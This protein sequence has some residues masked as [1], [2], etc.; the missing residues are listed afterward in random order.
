MKS[1]PWMAR[2]VRYPVLAVSIAFILATTVY[3]L[4]IASDLYVSEA[5]VI[6]ERTDLSSGQVTDI[7][8]L[9]TGASAQ[10][11][12]QLLLREYLL[13]TDVLRK[14]EDSLK[15]REHFATNGDWLSRLWNRQAPLELL[16][17]Y[18]ES[19]I[20]IELDDFSDVLVINVQAYTPQMSQ[21]IAAALL[22]EGE[23]YMNALGHQLA[24]EQVR[25]LE[26][27]VDELGRRTRAARS[28]LLAYQ[29]RSGMPSPQATADN[30]AGIVARLESQLTDLQTRRT[31]LLAFLQP[32]AP[33]VAEVNAQ[34]RAVESQLRQERAR[35]AAPQGGTL[36][37]AVEEYQRLQMEADFTQQVF[38]SA[39]ASLE[40]GRVDA[41]RTLKQVQVLQGA[42]K[43]EYP[44]RPRRI[45]NAVVYA[46]A[47][48]CL[49]G[50]LQL[51]VA[52]VRDHK[53]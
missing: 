13:S 22:G 9:L 25:F 3:W 44:L 39:L 42:S 12:D 30:Y 48:L 20:T 14:L 52:I 21:A 53:D 5:R 46:L 2:V 35:L 40:R 34:V 36:N 8:G 7:S 29:N 19:R 18:L 17:R 49:A 27:Q 38:N 16:H 11:P 31:G 10:R 6:L 15:L 45:Y 24:S 23:R 43:P 28:A 50:V 37:K 1:N 33:Q 26:A 41:T 32:E 4:L 51:L 47:A